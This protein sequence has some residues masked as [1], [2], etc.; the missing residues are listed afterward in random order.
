MGMPDA[1]AAIDARGLFKSFGDVRALDGF[2]M[3]IDAGQV[4]GL[5]GPNG[6]GKTTLL[7]ILF[8]LVAPDSGSMSLLGNE[9]SAAGSTMQGV[10][11]FVEDPRFYP[12]LSARRNLE[13]LAD[14]DGAGRDQVDDVLDLVRLSDRADR[15]VGGFSSGMRQR[16]GLAASLLRSPRVLLLDEPTVGLDPSG[17]RE[18]EVLLKGLAADGVTVLISSHNMTELDGSC[19]SVTAMKEGRSVWHGSMERLRSESPAPAHRMWTSDD[20][21]AIEVAD[22]DPR[23]SVVADPEG[24]VTVAADRDALDAYVM[25]LG[26]SGVAVRRLELLMTALESMFFALTGADE[27]G[28]AAHSQTDGIEAVT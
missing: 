6:A 13:L 16:L 4:H 12:Y 22:T 27:E 26:R 24:G 19:D 5:V 20:G 28:A 3:R 17:V 14:L 11:G 9:W 23:V 21:R 10:G 25:T 2:D 1:G 7:R 8:G 18:V 15:K